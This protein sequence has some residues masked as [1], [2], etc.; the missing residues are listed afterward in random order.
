M[1][2]GRDTPQSRIN[3][4]LTNRLLTIFFIPRPCGFRRQRRLRG[5]AI[6]L[7]GDGRNLGIMLSGRLGHLGHG[8]LAAENNVLFLNDIGY[9][10]SL[11]EEVKVLAD[12]ASYGASFTTEGIVVENIVCFVQLIA[13]AVVGILELEGLAF[14]VSVGEVGEGIVG[15]REAGGRRVVARGIEAEE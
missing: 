3:L 7:L 5:V 4:E 8:R 6:W 2:F 15:L 9:L 14:I 13:Q 12:F 1:L 11:A 10:G